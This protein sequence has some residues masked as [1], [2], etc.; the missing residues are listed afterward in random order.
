MKHESS[1]LVYPIP[2]SEIGKEK[3]IYIYGLYKIKALKVKE[4]KRS[5]FVFFSFPSFLKKKKNLFET[6]N[7]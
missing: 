5:N 4:K 6:G 2:L 3:K 7:E 1:L